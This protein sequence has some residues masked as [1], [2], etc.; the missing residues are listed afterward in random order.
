[1]ESNID[2]SKDFSFFVSDPFNVNIPFVFQ[3][4]ILPTFYEQILFP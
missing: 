1:M 4:S 2:N 3:V